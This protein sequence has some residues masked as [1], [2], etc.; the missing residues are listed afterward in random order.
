MF[1]NL[2]KEEKKEYYRTRMA[3]IRYNEAHPSVKRRT[4]DRLFFTKKDMEYIS[5]WWLY[6]KFLKKSCKDLHFGTETS[7]IDM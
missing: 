4:S 2:T 3:L 1:N 6:G 7:K 5:S